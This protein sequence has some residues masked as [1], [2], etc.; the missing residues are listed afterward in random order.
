MMKAT[1]LVAAVCFAT[2]FGV[3]SV[4][5]QN[6][7]RSEKHSFRVE[8]VA[9]GLRDPW[10][11]EMLPDGRFLVTERGGQL[12]IISADGKLQR[13]PVR[14]VPEVAARGQGG[15]LDVR[16]HPNHAQNG[17]IYLSYSKPMRGGNSTAI[18]R[19]RLKENALADI[20]TVFDPPAEDA[21][22]SA[23]HFGNRIEFDGKGFMYFSIGDRGFMANAQ[24]LSNINGKVHRLHDD[25]RVPQD[26]P[27]VRQAGARPSIW[28]YGNRNIQGLR[29]K[30]GTGELY[31]SEHGPRGGDELN[32][33]RKGLNYGWPVITYGINYDGSTITKETSRPGMEQPVKH[34]TPSPAFCGMDF[35]TG[36]KF[37]QW[38]GN[39]FVSALAL[40][41]VHRLVIEGQKVTHEET[42][43][44]RTGRIRDVRSFRDGFVYVIYDS[45]GRIVRL[46]PAE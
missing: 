28:S 44:E 45:P 2:A 38:K 15:L 11:M 13:D 33:I 7:V 20:E 31:A 12:R 24:Q 6:A 5:A 43:L 1:S 16:L 18:I 23:L 39:L 37:P 27:F 41:K 30:P 34:W 22:N 8:T 25:G 19:A 9:D 4:A 32:L 10:G 26:N 35:Y 17:W 36:D 3:G 21:V 29:F 40:Q 14:N 42:L 46:V